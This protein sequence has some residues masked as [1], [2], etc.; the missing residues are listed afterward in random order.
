[1][2]MHH[3]CLQD[4]SE[5][6]R[7]F[8][9]TSRLAVFSVRC[10]INPRGPSIGFLVHNCTCVYLLRTQRDSHINNYFASSMLL[11]PLRL[12]KGILNGYI[13]SSG[14]VPLLPVRNPVAL[15]EG[16]DSNPEPIWSL[17]KHAGSPKS[18]GSDIPIMRTPR[19]TMGY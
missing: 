14:H 2:N 6:L 5:V 15:K 11:I 17:R 9:N 8:C 16:L 13:S 7:R 12:P 4:L 1:M 10:Y 19:T 18:N 3:V